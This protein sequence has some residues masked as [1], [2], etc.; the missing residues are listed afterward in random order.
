[1]TWRAWTSSS[2]K[3]CSSST[4]QTGFQLLAGGLH[5]HPGDLLANQPVR[6]RLQPRGERPE[7]PHFLVASTTPVGHAHAR[8]HLALGDVHSAQ[9]ASRSS[10]VDT[11][12]GSWAAPGRAYRI[13][14]AETRARSNS[15]WWREGPASV[16]ST[17]SLA[18][19]RAELGLAPDS[20]LSWRPPAMRVF[21]GLSGDALMLAGRRW[22][23]HGRFKSDPWLPAGT[24]VLRPM[25]HAGGMVLPPGC[26]Q[27][28]GR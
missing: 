27:A 19:R 20:H 12:P 17:G 7:R 4:Y 24:E 18:P 13:G 6:Q 9:R 14:D 21:S 5:H 23:A 2:W 28:P 16:V 26:W 3:P 22:P 25:W 1:L 15:S 8:H 10:T 11:S